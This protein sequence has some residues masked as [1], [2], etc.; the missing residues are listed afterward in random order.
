MVSSIK[1]SKVAG[2][3]SSTLPG[4]CITDALTESGSRVCRIEVRMPGLKD[5][6]GEAS[7]Q[8]WPITAWP[9]PHSWDKSEGKG[10]PECW[11]RLGLEGLGRID[12]GTPLSLLE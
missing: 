2:L 3:G 7:S 4:R 6:R 5:R 8:G 10:T 9:E 12:L 1:E 11:L